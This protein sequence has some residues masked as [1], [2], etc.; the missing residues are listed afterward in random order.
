MGE[1]NAGS[2]DFAEKM[3]ALDTEQIAEEPQE[4]VAEEAVGESNDEVVDQEPEVQVEEPSDNAERSK[5]GRRVS[6]MEQLVNSINEKLDFIA[7]SS[8]KEEALVNDPEELLTAKEALELFE[9]LGTKKEQEQLRAKQ[10]YEKTYLQVA[11]SLSDEE[12]HEEVFKEMLENYNVKHSNDPKADAIINYKNAKIAILQKKINT[13]KVPLK[14]EKPKVPLG[15]NAG[16][17]VQ[18]P[19]KSMPKLD[20]DSAYLVEALK[21]S[22]DKVIAAYEK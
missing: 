19:K 2:Q 8:K 17:K 5:L 22:D 20:P 4:E 21:I 7:S 12:D 10:Q 18:T 6:Q 3:S 13:P 11:N 15:V 16:S 14:G 1:N 9:K